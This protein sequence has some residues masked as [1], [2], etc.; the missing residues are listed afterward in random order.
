MDLSQ[1]RYFLYL[2]ETLN[3]TR[4]AALSQISQPAL[5]K[6][7]RRLEEELGGQLVYR[8]GKDTRLTELGRTIRGEFEKIVMSAM[9]ARELADQVV[10]EDRT[11]I[12]LGVAATLAPEPVSGF[13]DAFL[14]DMREVEVLI[15]SINPELASELVLAGALDACFCIDVDAA[16]PKLQAIDLFRE[17]LLVATARD[18]RFATMAA[19]PLAEL[20]DESYLDRVNC[21]FRARPIE[22]F[23]DHDVVMHPQLRSDREDWIQHA[24]ARGFGITMLPEHSVLRDDIHLTSVSGLDL[25]RKVSLLTIFGSGTAPAIRRLRKAA[26]AH[27]WPE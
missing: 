21:D 12:T 9:R 3:F 26:K 1:I 2:A 6:A 7:I 5:T 10:N 25:S 19:V 4:A 13:L 27:D 24:V 8:G 17:R 18:H 11:I 15:E 22:Y 23:M 14:R 20:A 16:N